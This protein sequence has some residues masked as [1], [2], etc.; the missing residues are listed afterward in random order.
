MPA[1]AM[2]WFVGLTMTA[3]LGAVTAALPSLASGDAPSSASFTATDFAW[4]V[5]GG[6]ATEATIAEGGTVTF[7]YPS[8][9]N[10][11]NADFGT[12]AQPASCAQTA[13]TVSGTVPPLPHVPTPPGWSGTCTFS[14]PGTYTFHCDK[15]AFMTGTIVVQSTT[16]TATTTTTTTATTTT[17]TTTGTTPTSTT[18][19]PGTTPANTGTGTTP[20]SSTG[21]TPPMR[22]SVTAIVVPARQRGRAIRGSL[23]LTATGAGSRLVVTA[24]S[25]RSA[26]GGGN[27]HGLAR[28]GRAVRRSLRPGT[29]RF[30]VSLSPTARRALA[31]VG[32]MTVIVTVTITTPAGHRTSVMKQV[33]LLRG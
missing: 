28:V 19:T 30:S 15:H 14:T 12:G 33:V 2:R 3:S 16:T 31:R 26:L 7:G 17:A 18:T 9:A 6:T 29:V 8:G 5:S 25:P 4:Q 13:G 32:R 22:G 11:H 20:L 24:Q 27:A 1:H 21:A 10:D 23:R